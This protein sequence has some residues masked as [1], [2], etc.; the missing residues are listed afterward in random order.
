MKTEMEKAVPRPQSAATLFGIPIGEL[1]WF[2]SLL[3]GA[4]TGFAA[5][6]AATFL[7]IFSILL[8]NSVGHRSLDFALSYRRVGFPVGLVV[9]GTAWSY[10]GTLWL[11][12]QMS[13]R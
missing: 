5:F 4:A 13:R 9:L 8:V 3:M 10:L 11:R 6:F 2:A 7:G 1:G 12:R